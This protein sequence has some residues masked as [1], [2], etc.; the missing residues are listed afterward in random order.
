MPVGPWP[1]GPARRRVYQNCMAPDVAESFRI[2]RRGGRWLVIGSDG[3]DVLYGCMELADR[4]RTAGR[5]PSGIDVADGPAFKIRGTN[6]FW[7]KYG[8]KGYDWPVT[9][10]NFPWFF[11]RTLMP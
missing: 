4:V 10:E 8:D 5:L 6:L 2:L 11:D 1:F 7:M 3:P 9:R